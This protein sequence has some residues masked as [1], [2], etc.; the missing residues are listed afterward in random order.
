MRGGGGEGGGIGMGGVVAVEG[1]CVS[2]REKVRGG[3][4]VV[5]RVVY[6]V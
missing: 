1:G 5:K 6:V 4:C 3:V 2:V